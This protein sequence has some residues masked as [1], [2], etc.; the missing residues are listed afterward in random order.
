MDEICSGIDT[1]RKFSR[2]WRM[3]HPT[4]VSSSE[5]RFELPLFWCIYCPLL[6]VL[7]HQVKYIRFNLIGNFMTFRLLINYR[8]IH[9][10]IKMTLCKTEWNLNTT[11]ICLLIFSIFFICSKRWQC[12]ISIHFFHGW[13]NLCR[14]RKKYFSKESNL[15]KE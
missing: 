10:A 11:L 7:M 15:N 6:K 2:I 13:L 5:M 12:Q 4:I 9:F 14:S 8:L 3:S 1:V